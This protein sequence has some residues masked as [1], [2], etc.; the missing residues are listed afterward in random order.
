MAKL[1]SWIFFLQ[2]SSRVQTTSIGTFPMWRRNT[3]YRRFLK[4]LCF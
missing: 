1:G 2:N 4:R 3:E